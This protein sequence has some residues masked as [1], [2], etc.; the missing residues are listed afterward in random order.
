MCYT[1]YM[2]TSIS[3]DN[4]KWY[5]LFSALS[6]IANSIVDNLAEK[7]LPKLSKI[8]D[9]HSLPVSVN[10]YKELFALRLKEE[11]LMDEE[12]EKD[13]TE[14]NLEDGVDAVFEQINKNG[15]ISP[16]LD[17]A[18]SHE[19]H[20]TY[21]M[22]YEAEVFMNH[23]IRC[24]P[25]TEPKV[26]NFE[27][28]YPKAIPAEHEDTPRDYFLAVLLD[29]LTHLIAERNGHPS[30]I[31]DDEWEATLT[32]MLE[33]F[34]KMRFHPETVN[35]EDHRSIQLYTQYYLNLWD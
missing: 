11:K 16:E 1:F 28:G 31:P 14:F 12:F 6:S 29:G 21:L 30:L 27:E 34:N 24:L 4:T 25:P 26:Y 9:L 13:A 10:F 20:A 7:P 23:I 17:R 32:A 22:K 33:T 18:T 19:A 3:N 5:D 2:S 15:N 35:F 8:R